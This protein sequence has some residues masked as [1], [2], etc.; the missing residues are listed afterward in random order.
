MKVFVSG[1][2]IDAADLD[3]LADFWGNLLGMEITRREDEWI[4]LGPSLARSSAGVHASFQL[5]R[6]MTGA[7]STSSHSASMPMP[8][9]AS[10]NANAALHLPR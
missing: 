10:M 5:S 2:V 3:L 9:D 7:S 4:S 6:I 8:V 1:V